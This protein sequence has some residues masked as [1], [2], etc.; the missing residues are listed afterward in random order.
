MLLGGGRT[1]PAKWGKCEFA[2]VSLI[3]FCFYGWSI[4]ESAYHPGKYSLQNFK[5]EARIGLKLAW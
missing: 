1:F 2:S 4:V 3:L 5:F